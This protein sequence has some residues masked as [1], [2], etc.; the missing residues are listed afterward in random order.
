MQRMCTN[1]THAHCA[2]AKIRNKCSEQ[3]QSNRERC[4]AID[5]ID[6]PKMFSIALFLPTELFAQDCVLWEA[7]HYAFSQQL[8]GAPISLRNFGT[9]G[10]VLNGN[11]FPAGQNI[12]TRFPREC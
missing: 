8:F 4:C 12:A 3:R 11:C 9:I 5:R 7:C 10:L 2:T 6:E 1:Q